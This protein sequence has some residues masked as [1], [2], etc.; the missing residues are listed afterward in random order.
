MEYGTMEQN[1]TTGSCNYSPSLSPSP[2]SL[3][4]QVSN[5][6]HSL[7]RDLFGKNDDSYKILHTSQGL[8]RA[9]HNRSIEFNI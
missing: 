9:L 6:L 7:I 4:K 8:P 2:N 5:M 3:V 1:R